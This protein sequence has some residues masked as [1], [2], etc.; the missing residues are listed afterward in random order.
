MKIR[1]GDKVMISDRNPNHLGHGIT[2]YAGWSGTVIELSNNGAFS[3]DC[4]GRILTIA[5]TTKLLV[6]N[7]A[8]NWVLIKHKI[9]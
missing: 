1:N 9:K 2:A 3:I 6:E 4:G 5:T 7:V 8:G